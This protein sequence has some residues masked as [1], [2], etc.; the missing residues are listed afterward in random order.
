MSPNPVLKLSNISVQNFK[1]LKDVS[2]DLLSPLAVFV[3]R[4]NT[5]KS[6]ILDIFEFIKQA[7]IVFW[8]VLVR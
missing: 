8:P 7:A 3:G 2:I 6:S 5:G 1:S 4:N